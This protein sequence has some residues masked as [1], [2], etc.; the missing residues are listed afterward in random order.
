MGREGEGGV[1]EGDGFV[2]FLEGGSVVYGEA[3]VG[4]DVCFFR[5]GE[6]VDVREGDTFFGFI[7]FCRVG[8]I[9]GVF[10]GDLAYVVSAKATVAVGL[11]FQKVGC[12]DLEDFS[13]WN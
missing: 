13:E 11:V 9:V 10:S 4:E 1:R 7:V 5:G 12:I 8:V 2:R 3:L 6:G